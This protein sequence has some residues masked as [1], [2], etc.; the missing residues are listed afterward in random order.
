MK[1]IAIFASGNGTNAQ[2]IT[3]YFSDNPNI[4][5]C[6]IITNNKD[7]FVLQRAKK[8]NI[9]SIYFNRR[10]F[11]E[12]EKIND[13][14]KQNSVDLIV[15]AGFLWLIPLK[16]IKE[17]NGKIIN[18]HPALLPKFGGKGMYGDKV[19][20]AV[21]ESCEKE[22]GISIHFVNEKYDEGKII[23]QKK[24]AIQSNDNL[25]SLAKKIHQLEYKYFP[26]VIEN[27]L[28]D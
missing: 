15:L 23:F 14:L 21:I 7:A 9:P 26:Q 5:V 18:I 20:K 11:Y 2:R 28:N 19:H 1:N 12:T 17:F 6:L 3:E 10:D 8:L 24:I 16:L 4:N 25:E 27:M 13:I 22:S